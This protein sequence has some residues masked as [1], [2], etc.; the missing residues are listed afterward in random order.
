MAKKSH[1]IG[2]DLGTAN[3]LVYINGSGVVYNEPSVVAFDKRTND[4]I[5]VGKRAAEMLGKEHSQIRLAK[6]LEG[7]VI[8]DLEATRVYIQYVFEKLENISVDLKNSTLLLCCPSEVS[9]IEK[10]AL[11]DL[12][13]KI[14]V[15][16]A[17]VEQELKAGAIGAGI[18]IFEASGSMVVDIGGGTTDIGVLSLGDLVISDSNKIAGNYLDKEITK[19]VKYKYGI[20]IGKNT[21]ENIKIQLGTLSKELKEDKEYTFAGRNLSNGLPCKVTMKQSEVKEIFVRAFEAIVN[22]IRKVLQ[23]TPPELSSDIFNNGIVINGG[24]ALIHGIKEFFEDELHLQVKISDNP[25]TS[26]VE[27]TKLLLNNRGNYLVKPYDY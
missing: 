11:L 17:F 13:K 24:G 10:V 12:A 9:D 25:L 27:G 21:A 23:Q 3:I 15:G 22:S 7:G 6:P 14:G 20:I 18:D 4:C 19:Y 5:A 16:D 26:I 8:A 1:K 2:V